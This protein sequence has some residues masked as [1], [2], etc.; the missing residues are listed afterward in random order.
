MH[1]LTVV[2]NLAEAALWGVLAA[3]AGM[4]AV[5]SDGRQRRIATVLALALLAFGVSDVIESRTGA[6][7]RPPA[8]LMLK[9]ACLA[10][11]SGVASVYRRERRRSANDDHS[12]RD[13]LDAE[14]DTAPII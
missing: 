7:W 1:D 9:G 8:L 10:V 13:D 2:G 11:F 14:S 5:R 3:F 12:R 6:W 4:S